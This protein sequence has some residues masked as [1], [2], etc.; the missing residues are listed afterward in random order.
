[1]ALI[2]SIASASLQHI[3]SVQVPLE[4]ISFPLITTTSKAVAAA[5]SLLSLYCY[6]HCPFC[7][8]SSVC[9]INDK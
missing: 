1:M 5:A 2:V 3:V 7:V 9:F 8:T 4:L 6:F